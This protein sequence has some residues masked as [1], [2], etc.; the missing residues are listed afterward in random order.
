MRTIV[1]CAALLLCSA[2]FASEGVLLLGDDAIREGR[3]GAGVAS[4]QDASWILL[5][6]AGLVDLERRVDFGLSLIFPRLTLHT[7]GIGQDFFYR[8]MTD[9]GFMANPSVGVVWP[10]KSGSSAVTDTVGLGFYVPA[11]AAIH[12]PRSRTWVGALE[13]RT[14]RNLDFMQPR[15]TLAYAHRF[16]SEWA[17][18][19]S[20]NGS[21]SAA[22]TDQITPYLLP[23]RGK[24]EWDYAFGAGFGVG[25]YRR[26][27]RWSF[28]AAVESRQ[29]SQVFDKYRDITPYPVDLPTTAQTGAAYRI[30]PRLEIEFDYRFI[31]WSN[32]RFFHEPSSRN[33]LGWHDQH[34]VMGGIEWQAN[35]RWT[36]RAGYSHMTPAMD[37]E[38]VFGSA[39][40]PLVV[41]DH[42]A[43]GVT[44]ALT[45]HSELHL[46]FAHWFQGEQTESGRGDFYSHA[47]KGTRSTLAADWIS[48][49]YS[50]KF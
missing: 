43:V 13:G 21:L 45:D 22:R 12:F 46:A 37:N 44:H 30:T 27:E 11:G 5:N 15:L 26:W 2:A 31:N 29:W 7:R 14:D 48:L 34:G 24:N 6:P 23:T 36:F 41:T 35:P 38:H 18:G 28:G 3:G 49:G 50:R 19:L 32:T 25:V 4:P 33:G 9:D 10:L 8:D 17:L 1:L 47:G 16:D 42:A 40:V 39:L 20:I